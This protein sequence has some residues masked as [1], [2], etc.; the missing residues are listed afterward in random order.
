MKTLDNFNDKDI[1]KT[2]KLFTQ[3]N[4][5]ITKEDAADQYDVTKHKIFDKNHRP[6]KVINKDT[7]TTDD[8]GASVTQRAII[9]VGRIGVSFQEQVVEQRV[10]FTLSIPIKNNIRPLPENGEKEISAKDKQLVFG[11]E[12]ILRDNRMYFRNKE[13]LRRQMSE[14]ECAELWYFART[15]KLTLKCKVLSPELGD[16]LYPMYDGYGDMIAFGRGYITKENYKNVE[17]FEIYT[18]DSTYKFVR[19]QGDEWKKSRVI[20]DDRKVIPNP[21]KN[22]IGKIPIVYHYQSSPEWYRVQNLIERFEDSLSN[23]GDMNDYFGSPI[24]A[25]T[26]Q[27]LGFAAKGESGKIL[28]LAQEAKASFLTLTTPPESIKMEQ[29]QL[30]ELIY[31]LTRTADISFDKVKGI[32]NLSGV[33]LQLLFIS[34]SM[35]SKTKEETLAV[36]IQRRINIIKAAYGK[37]INSSLEGSIDNIISDPEI[38]VYVPKDIVEFVE[39]LGTAKMQGIMSTKKAV[40]LNPEIDD[41]IVELKNIE[42]E[43]EIRIKNETQ[44]IP[45][46]EK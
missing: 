27:I 12:K 1:D 15:P 7:G 45:K 44:T 14:M 24:L 10:G 31:S 37:V 32:G 20:G 11:I 28:E 36:S 23:H 25:V 30:R 34:S 2:I 16:T 13:V 8:D 3:S 19:R 41:P 29:F 22:P 40:E 43:D 33:A 4:F 9:P 39:M 5:E 26:G 38:T 46:T 42:G 18:K 17:R 35:A 21:S 6:D